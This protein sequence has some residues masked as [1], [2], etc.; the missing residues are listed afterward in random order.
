[1][2]F[3]FVLDLYNL[4]LQLQFTFSSSRKRC[5]LS[6]EKCPIFNWILIAA[7]ERYR[8]RYTSF[9]HNFHSFDVK[10][11]QKMN[12]LPTNQYS[13][14]FPH[15]TWTCRYMNAIVVLVS[16]IVKEIQSNK[17]ASYQYQQF[18]FTSYNKWYSIHTLNQPGLV[19]RFPF[20]TTDFNTRQV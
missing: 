20:S 11:T 1:M 16:L 18:P 5:Q 6:L 9:C 12:S 3:F 17:C 7:F 10:T 13:K 15:F 14:K 2:N 19:L 8:C 4:N